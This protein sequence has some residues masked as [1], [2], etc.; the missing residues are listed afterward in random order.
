MG[1]PLGEKYRAGLAESANAE[2]GG[3]CTLPEKEE[4]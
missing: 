3:P 1:P 2:V 4:K